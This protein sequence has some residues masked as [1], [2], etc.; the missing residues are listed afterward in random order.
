M[1]IHNKVSY[2]KVVADDQEQRLD[3]LLIRLLKNVP[4]SRIYR[5]IRTGEVRINKARKNALYKVQAGDL[6][7]IPPYHNSE[8]NEQVVEY[9][10]SVIFNALKK[11]TLYEDEYLFVLNKPS[12]MMVHGNHKEMGIIEHLR[13]KKDHANCELAHRLDKDTSGCLVIAKRRS[14]LR[15]LHEIFRSSK[16]EKR[17]YALVHGIWQKDKNKVAAPLERYLMPNGERRVRVS[18]DGK[19][20]L[21]RFRVIA[22]SVNESLLDIKLE[23]GKTHQIRVHCQCSGH[24]VLFDDKYGDRKLDKKNRNPHKRLAL[25]AYEIILTHPVTKQRLCINSGKLQTIE[26]FAKAFLQY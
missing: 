9:K 12:G 20:A 18:K 17:Y 14:I 19:P 22:Q 2:Y 8:N 16:V 3:N 10:S 6:V 23:T 13:Q 5:M 11:P 21:T 7:R 25:H 1:N 15:Q 26:G 4:K 24:P